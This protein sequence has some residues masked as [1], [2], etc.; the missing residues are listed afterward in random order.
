MN[1]CMKFEPLSNMLFVQWDYFNRLERL[2]NWNLDSKRKTFKN[3]QQS[4]YCFIVKF[5]V[6]DRV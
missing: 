1:T 6:C 5:D 3:F 2:W 4:K